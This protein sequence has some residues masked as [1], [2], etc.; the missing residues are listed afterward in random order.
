MPSLQQQ[1]CGDG[2]TGEQAALRRV[3]TLVA[4]AAPPEQV[5]AA[6]T[7]EAGRLLG[8]DQA[9]MSRYVPEGTVVVAAWGKAGA[10]FPVGSGWSLGGPNVPTLVYRTGRPA[11]TDDYADPSDLITQAAR[12]HGLLSL[13]GVPIS[14]EGRL[15]GIMLVGCVR[16]QPLPPDTEIRLAAFTEL[17]ATAI[18]NAQA[19]VDLRGF[20]DE[21]AA[22]RRVATLVARGTPPG[23]VFAAVAAEAG[24]L[25]GADFTFLSR[26]GAA[27]AATIT[28]AWAR[29]G[30]AGVL[31]AGSRWGIG[32]RNLHTIVFRTGRPA[33]M[34]D[35]TGSL[36]SLAQ[37]A[38]GLGIRSAVAAPISVEGRLW[39]AMGVGSV[40]E[41]PLPAVTEARLAGF[42]ELAATAIA[43]MQARVELSGFA[44]E[45]AALR[46]VAT[47]VAHGAPPEEV[48]ALITAEA[49][50]LLDTHRAL[51]SRYGSQG[52]TV[53]ASWSSTSAAVPVGTEW[54]TGGRNLHTTVTQ[55]HQPARIDNYTGATGPAAEAREVGVRSGVAVPISVEGRLWGL[56]VVS[57]TRE[58]PLPADTEARLAAF[59]ELAA[60]AI[61]NSE[62][63][64]AL[65]ASRA[66]IVVTAD[67][68]RRR[69]ERDLHDGAQQRLVSLALQLREARAAVP[70]GAGK[71]AQ[72]LG[73]AVTDV[74]SVLDELRE[75]A[76]G[77]HPAILA[78]GGLRPALAALARRSVIPV[79]L[80][81]Q[82]P[83]RLPEQAEIAAYYVVAEALTNTAKHSHAT[84][85][86]V[87]VS[88]S[89]DIVRV[90]VRD[91]G[92][93]GADLAHGSGLV[94]LRDRTEALGGQLSL[95]SPPGAGTG[96]EITLPLGGPAGPQ[97]PARV[98]SRPGDP[99]RS[100]AVELEPPAR[101]EE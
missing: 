82:V 59:T 21:Q 27:R 92:L 66:R 54:I 28:G 78:E 10:A 77:L 38:R 19:R 11:R 69:I 30:T 14:V 46:R 55:T 29:T 93:G 100:H 73:D 88:A 5:F 67:Q 36:G 47:L 64:A 15:W 25:L 44:D 76:R 42:T 74:M 49:G 99:A 96:I 3:A 39:G 83:A 33:R 26:Y 16:E 62:T 9:T 68:T 95:D 94:G 31:S 48:L 32:G 43:N 85:V 61:A 41:E 13:V 97:L 8:V 40:R 89:A 12:E 34:D 1:T 87:Q 20:A 2:I 7:E 45:Q 60:T 18:A 50:R 4:R 75:T 23:E 57:S 56:M 17:A 63:Q 53:V 90:R 71:L 22:L 58:E 24:R 35:Y 51:M 101:H 91:D 79:R 65:A 81:V 98:V 37:A 70:P 84:A 80:D 86:D 52:A 6:V 72:Q